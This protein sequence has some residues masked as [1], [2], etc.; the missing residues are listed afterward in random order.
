VRRLIGAV[1][2]VTALALPLGAQIIP[3]FPGRPGMGQLQPVKRDTSK[4]TTNKVHWPTPDSITARLLARPGYTIT[5]YQGDTAFF[6]AQTHALDLLA[7]NKRRAIVDRDS[8]IVVSDSGIYYTETD[9][10]VVTGGKYTLSPPPS[11]GQADIKGVGRV[12]YDLADRSARITRAKLP[13]NNGQMWYMDVA[14]ARVILDT[15]KTASPTVFARGGSATSCDDSIPDYRFEFKEAK[16][17]GNNTLVARPAILYIKDIPVLW[18]PFIFTDTRSGRHSGLLPPMFGFGDIVRNSPTYRRHVEHFGY[19]WALSDYYD[20][21]T[22]LDWRSAAGASVNDPGWLRFNGDFNYKWVNRFMAGRVGASYTTQR[23]GST[24]TAVSWGHQQEFSKDSRLNTN[25]NFVTNTTLQRQNTFNPITAL[26]T[27]ASQVSYQTK[28]G[29]ASLNLGATRTQY[30]GRKQI[31]QSLPTISLTSTAISLGPHFSWTPTF[32]YSRHDV[33]HMDQPGPGAFVFSVDPVT[34]QRDSTQSTTRNSSNVSMDIGLPLQIFGRDFRNTF[35]VTQQRQNFPQQFNIVDVETGQ[36]TATRIFAATYQTAIDWTP[37]FTV[38]SLGHNKFNLSP[39]ISLQNVEPGPFWVASERTNG[40]YVSQSKRISLGVGATPTLYARFRGF[41]PW[42]A[43]R[44]SITPSIAYSWAPAAEVSDEYLLALGRTRANSFTGLKQSN[45]SFG[46]NQLFQAKL[47]QKNDSNPD[48]AKKIDLLSLNFTPI[49]YD[50]ERAKGHKSTAGFTS[51]NWGY[52]LRSDLLPGFDFSSTYSLFLGSTLSD[53]AEFKPYLTNISA[54]FRISREQNPFAALMRLFGRAVPEAQA[55][56]A[57]GTDQVRQRP[58]SS[59]L[60]LI[61]AQPIAGSMRTG[62]RFIVPPTE[63]WR[64]SFSFTRSSP[65][66]PKP[67]SNVIDFDPVARCQQV[68]GQN[69]LLL[70]ACIQQQRALPTNDLPVTSATAGGPVYNI[71]PTTSINADIAFNLTPKW[72]AHWTTNY[73]VE[74]HQFAS[75]IVQLQRDLHDW[76]A[77]F[78]YTQSPN[79]NFAFTFTISLKAEPD[80]KFDYNR[81]T[82]RSGFP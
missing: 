44:H 61:A 34:G 77:L 70:E 37:D 65:R 4:D 19:Y 8:Q 11:S 32:S 29:P 66:P 58:D 79:G 27:I 42:S 73:D 6:N 15:G 53:T 2:L 80:I 30:P 54:S 24:N 22:W 18:L 48:N 62:D 10:K 69:A 63:G 43:I 71:P 59:Q 33:L 16:R 17:T 82:V 55:M 52:S 74:T 67:G 5:R 56:P 78:G 41:G 60:A 28:L 46:L 7:A 49:T 81:S 40:R 39:S 25:I 51:E 47:R 3:G 64:A 57:A 35:H 72:A 36:V 14:L 21:S 9:R 76:R 12:D 26:A 45:I 1:T 31:D 75:Q 20:F 68:A 38:P 23:D 50:F 13:V